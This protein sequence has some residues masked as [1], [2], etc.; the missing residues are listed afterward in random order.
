MILSK[1]AS[2]VEAIH[3]ETIVES[4]VFNKAQ[5]FRKLT[6]PTQAKNIKCPDC[7]KDVG[8]YNPPWKAW[9]CMQDECLVEWIPVNSSVRKGFNANRK[10]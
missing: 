7:G 10:L 1:S 9:A 2:C 3:P 8:W 5:C 6:Q 4:V